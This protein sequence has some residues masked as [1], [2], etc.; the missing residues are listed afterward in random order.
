MEPSYERHLVK[1]FW[2]VYKGEGDI[3]AHLTL[4]LV[5]ARTYGE[6]IGYMR[7]RTQERQET[8]AVLTKIARTIRRACNGYMGLDWW[9]TRLEPAFFKRVVE[10]DGEEAR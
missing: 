1:A 6:R 4:V 9:R 8:N 10:A 7:G 5:K 2:E 3:D